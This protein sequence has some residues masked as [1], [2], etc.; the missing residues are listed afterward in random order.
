VNQH[1]SGVCE[2]KFL[3]RQAFGANIV[4]TD[5]EVFVSKRLKESWIKIRREHASGNTDS[6][7]KP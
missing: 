1:Q 3:L 5:F 4:P 7:T 6:R 2:V